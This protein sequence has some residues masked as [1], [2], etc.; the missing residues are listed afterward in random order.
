M[1]AASLPGKTANLDC[2][3]GAPP[4]FSGHCSPPPQGS[5]SR[6]GV[7]NGPRRRKQCVES[8]EVT[9]VAAT[10]YLR[11]LGA[12]F[13]APRWLCSGVPGVTSSTQARS[14]SSATRQP[15][16]LLGERG[17]LPNARPST[18]SR[19][20]R[21]CNSSEDP[22][23]TPVNGNSPR[24]PIPDASTPRDFQQRLA[25]AGGRHACSCARTHRAHV[26]PAAPGA[27]GP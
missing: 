16:Q 9:V 2:K 1:L 14:G 6:P 10:L 15:H 25:G 19:T 18:R 8:E 3:L 26:S 5:T 22:W 4:G 21:V 24:P 11:C 7:K 23:P 27:R 13:K 17:C 20:A 12:R